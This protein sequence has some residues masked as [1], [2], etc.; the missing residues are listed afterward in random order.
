MKN[1]KNFATVNFA[2]MNADAFNMLSTFQMFVT[3]LSLTEKD[4]KKVKDK[5][6]EEGVTDKKDVS[7]KT[8]KERLAK[9]NAFDRANG[10]ALTFIIR[11]ISTADAVSGNL[12]KF[13]MSEFLHNIGVLSDGEIDKKS[14]KK[15]E[16][17]RALVVD[18]VKVGITKRKNGTDKLTL[19]DVKEVKNTPIELVLAIVMACIDSGAI[20]YSKGGLAF[21]KFDKKSTNK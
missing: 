5:L 4:L 9:K 20:E 14:I 11:Y 19:G 3:E 6:K 16:D 15:I 10:Q 21:V 7:A 12:Y 17:I 8:E 1:T 2:N 13:D 18:R